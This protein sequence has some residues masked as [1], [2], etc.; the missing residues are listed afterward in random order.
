MN[1]AENDTLLE[2]ISGCKE[3]NPKYQHRLYELYAKRMTA[4]CQRYCGDYETALDL[5]HDGFVR[6]FN[7][8]ESYTGDGNFE[9]WLKKIFVNIALDKIRRRDALKMA[10]EVETVENYVADTSADFTEKSDIKQIMNAI[11]QLPTLARTIFNMYNI[12]GYSIDEIAKKL[13][14]TSTA[15]RS[16]HSRAKKRLQAMLKNIFE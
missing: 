1:F 8:I 11:E 9:G 13:N 15:V 12:D 2:I 6:V 16:Q 7:F 14:M 5:M 3:H 10:L 4:L